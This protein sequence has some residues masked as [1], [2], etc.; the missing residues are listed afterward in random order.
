M[1]CVLILIFP[2]DA[3]LARPKLNPF[4]AVGNVHRWD[5]Y[6]AFGGIVANDV[7]GNSICHAAQDEQP[8][9][10]RVFLNHLAREDDGDN[11]FRLDAILLGL[12]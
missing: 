5:D 3:R 8:L 11:V 6:N 4:A 10:I 7:K 2:K 9:P 1:N 12:D